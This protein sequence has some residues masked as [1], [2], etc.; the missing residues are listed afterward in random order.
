LFRVSDSVKLSDGT[1]IPCI[2]GQCGQVDVVSQNG[3]RYK[4]GFWD[5]VLSD[6]LIIEAINSRDMFG[7]IE[8]PEDD[9]HYLR[10]PYEL[11]SHVIMKAWCENGNPFAHIGLLNN[12]KGNQIKALI[13]VGHRPGV[14]TRGLGSFEKDD[15]SQYIS[16]DNYLFLGWDIVRSPN[17]AD[18]KLDKVTDSLMKSPIFEEL[19]QMHQLKD[20]VDEHYSA[21]QLARGMDN[22]ISAL[23]ELKKL[24]NLN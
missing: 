20:S 14:S 24:L 9:D 12:E 10:T 15:I 4:K 16:E 22:A 13:D 7:M 2:V 23:L 21:N 11:A 18:L 19:V 3:Y 8:H 6:P 17:F 5:K 1:T